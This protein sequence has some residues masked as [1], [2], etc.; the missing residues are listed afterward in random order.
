MK[1][2][3]ER[4]E[5]H[6]LKDDRTAESS[7]KPG[8]AHQASFQQEATNQTGTRIAVLEAQLLEKVMVDI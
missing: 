2:V 1:E 8:D 3:N 5:K 6:V 7:S 4:D